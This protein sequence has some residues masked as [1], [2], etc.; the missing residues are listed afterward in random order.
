MEI[1]NAWELNANVVKEV[2]G[3]HVDYEKRFYL[4]PYCGEPVYEKDWSEETLEE[5]I[6]PIFAKRENKEE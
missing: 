2:F 4:C 6:C 3:G 1:K 5:F